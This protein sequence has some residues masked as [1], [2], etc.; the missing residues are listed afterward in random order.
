M[1]HSSLLQPQVVWEQPDYMWQ[2]QLKYER[3]VVAQRE[4]I[5]A[6][7]HYPTPS[8]RLALTDTIENEHCFYKVRTQACSCL[9]KVANAMVATWQGP[10]AMMA[11]FRKMFGSHSCPAIIRQNNFTNFQ[12]YFIL[13]VSQLHLGIFCPPP[14]PPFFLF[15]FLL[16]HSSHRDRLMETGSQSCSQ[17]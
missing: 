6:L 15:F 5:F 2:Y 13:K 14:C 1:V 8:T 4:A 16:F 10:P 11:I 12:H 9:T 3:D 17:M 7:E